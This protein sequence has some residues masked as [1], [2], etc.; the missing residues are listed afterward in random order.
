MATYHGT[1]NAGFEYNQG[2]VVRAT[3]NNYY[4]ISIQNQNLSHPTNDTAW[5]A[6]YSFAEGDVGSRGPIGPVG[7]GSIGPR[8]PIGPQG[9]IGP[10]GATGVISG[11]I[12]TSFQLPWAEE[13]TLGFN[14]GYLTSYSTR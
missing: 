7:G 3:A 6:I 12:N 2:D 14:A 4:Y 1:Y 11:G 13:A 5:W 10:R 8:G 9:P